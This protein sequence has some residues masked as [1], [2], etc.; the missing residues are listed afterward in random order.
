[1]TAIVTVVF[2]TDLETITAA[3]EAHPE[4]IQAILAI[5]KDYMIG[6]QRYVRDGRV[7]DVDQYRSAEDYHAFFAQAE[8]F[9][10]QYAAN[11]GAT[12]TDTLWQAV[13]E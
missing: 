6:H 10:K 5:A 7:M 11:A 8:P 9:I 2:D 12:V 3:E 13:G 4:A 1:M